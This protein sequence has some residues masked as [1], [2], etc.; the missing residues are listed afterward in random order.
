MTPEEIVAI[1]NK[2]R[3]DGEIDWSHYKTNDQEC[4]WSKNWELTHVF[5]CTLSP[6]SAQIIAAHYHELGVLHEAD[7]RVER[8]ERTEESEGEKGEI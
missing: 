1:L 2:N 4:Y 7:M 3:H 6:A 8:T 5:G